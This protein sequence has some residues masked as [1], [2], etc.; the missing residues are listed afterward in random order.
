V[1]WIPSNSSRLGRVQTGLQE[2]LE[3]SSKRRCVSVLWRGR[4]HAQLVY[5]DGSIVSMHPKTV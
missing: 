5:D 4:S 3:L 2:Y 1:S